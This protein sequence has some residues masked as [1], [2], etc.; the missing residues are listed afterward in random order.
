MDEHSFDLREESLREYKPR[1]LF[2][3]D[4]VYGGGDGLTKVILGEFLLCG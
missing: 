4:Q 2:F 1:I 3:Q